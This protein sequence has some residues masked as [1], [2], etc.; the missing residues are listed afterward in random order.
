MNMEHKIKPRDAKSNP[1]TAV[2]A[3]VVVMFIVSGL[4]LLLLAMLL[5]KM[6]LSESVVKVGVVVVYVVSG[7]VGGILMGKIMREQKFLWG[8][9]A[10]V[11]YFVILFVV[12][13]LFKGGIDVEPTKLVTTFILCAA[14][15]M[16][17]GMVS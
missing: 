8:L 10:G 7:L 4:L 3:A 6:D 16:A 5:Y 15:G 14:S 1:A 11:L 2:A 13:M 12:S 17:G 9:A